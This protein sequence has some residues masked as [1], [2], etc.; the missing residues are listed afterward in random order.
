MAGALAQ[1]APAGSAAMAACTA[2]IFGIRIDP[3]GEAPLPGPGRDR[4]LEGLDLRQASAG[5]AAT[6]AWRTGGLRGRDRG[7]RFL[8]HEASR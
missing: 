1:R 4:Q 3:Y 8:V 2:A 7:F 5:A 6:G